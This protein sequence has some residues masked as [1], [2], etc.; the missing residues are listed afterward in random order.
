MKRLTVALAAAVLV[1]LP[2]LTGQ[3]GG[4]EAEKK[5]KGQLLAP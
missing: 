5:L 2:S 4:Q 3:C 1:A